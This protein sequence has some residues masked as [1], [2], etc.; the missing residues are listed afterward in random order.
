MFAEDLGASCIPSILTYL[1]FKAVLKKKKK[2]Q[3][4]EA[5]VILQIS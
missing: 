2:K 1:L 5:D 4:Y 3:F